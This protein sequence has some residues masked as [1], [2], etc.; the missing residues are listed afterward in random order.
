MNTPIA[1]H[2]RRLPRLARALGGAL[3]LAA[4]LAGTAGTVQLVR[5][6]NTTLIP[7]S[8]YPAP[9]GSLGGKM[10]FG[11]ADATGPALW[12][13]DGTAGGTRVLQRL[14]GLGILPDTPWNDFLVQG[15][16]A[17]V[18][19]ADASGVSSV[20]VTDGTAGGTSR[21][22]TLTGGSTGTPVLEGLLNT[23]VIIS[24]VDTSLVGQL[25]ATDGTP[26]GTHQL[27]TFTAQTGGFLNGFFVA[28]NK[29][30]FVA[31]DPSYNRSIWVSDGTAAGTHQISSTTSSVNSA[32]L[33][34]PQG[35]QLVGN[36]ILYESS[37]LLWSIDTTTDAI[38]NVIAS[39]GIAGFGPPTVQ[40]T[41]LAN[42]GG[43]VLFLGSS[44]IG[45]QNN[46]ELWRSDG[47]TAGTTLV[48]TVTAN[49]TQIEL[50]YPLFEKVGNKVVYIG[51]DGVNGPQ[52]WSSDGTLA[53]TIRLTSATAPASIIFQ[54]AS[55]LS[56]IGGTAY[57]LISDGASTTTYSLWRTDGSAAG[58]QRL[59]G[60][61]TID[62]GEIGAT[63]IAG[64]ATTVYFGVYPTLGAPGS[65]YKY[66]PASNTGTLAKAG[67][68]LFATDEFAFNGG[69]LFFSV[70]DPVVG[71]EPWVSDGTTAGTRLIE[72][73]NPQLA[74]NGSSPDGFV[75]FGGRLAFAADDGIAGRELW[76]SDG[77]AGGTTL[78]ADIN[79]GIA[80][81]N[82]NH[83]FVANDALYFFATDASGSSKFMRLA[84]VGATAQVLATLSPQAINVG[85]SCGADGAVAMGTQI[86]FAANDGQT[87][88]ELWTS[89]GTAEGTHRVA[90]IA[91]GAADA[92]PCYLTALNGRVYFS[93]N[94]P[95]GNELWSS[96]GTAAGT[97]QVADIAPGTASSNPYDLMAFNGTLYF[98]ADDMLHGIELW[99][100]DGTAGGTMLVADIVP[101]ADGSIP[102]LQGILNGRLLLQIFL[103]STPPGTYVSQLW[104]SD[105]TSGGTQAISSQLFTASPSAFVNGTHVFLGAQ[106]TAGVTPWVS[107]GTSGGT[108]A[109]IPPGN[110][111][112]FFFDDFSGITLFEVPDPTKGAQLWRT[113][114]T[115]AGTKLVSVEPSVTN[116]PYS[117]S[118]R[119]HLTV[120]Q[121]FF[122]SATDPI[123]GAELYALTNDPPVAV[124][125]SATSKEDAAVTIDVLAN[126][127]DSDGSLDPTT[128]AI[129]TNP[130]HGS[131]VVSAG[132]VIYTPSTGFAGTDSF[133]Y[134]VK[135]N[136]GATSAPAVITVTVT[137]AVA[138]PPTHGGGGGGAI[139]ALQLL[140][141]MLL[142]AAQFLRANRELLGNC[143]S[144]RWRGRT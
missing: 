101:G 115:T 22:M 97:F 14:T 4:P 42:M 104:S 135:D 88:L 28:A 81:S 99:K 114:G 45:I 85:A 109:L 70:N 29:F 10:L 65:I 6:I 73:L 79:P 21:V 38:S 98:S 128:I 87:G 82:P 143:E 108:H 89:D 59:G 96:D 123:L 93:A 129:T 121:Q 133:A 46:L 61:P 1:V 120:G 40:G 141:A 32:A 48:T 23:T 51:D 62:V 126:D 106:D 92:A 69:L 86:Y 34:N 83:L 124:A 103:G 39:S 100:S 15:S 19:S 60:L 16:R 50:S 122:F 119:Q 138:P 67:L 24:N 36:L 77:T 142:W 71:D 72:D 41:V 31:S 55:P 74:G 105:G 134:T 3:L 68:P 117:A 47:T 78:L 91:A 54:V 27:T 144:W 37:G 118:A 127:S 95:Q 130:A 5:N 76:I 116:T 84:K 44:G 17:F 140:G 26:A 90:D 132:K 125:D 75:N 111:V 56:V 9:L 8:S 107:D 63:R 25:F 80:S 57:V 49:A 136:Q 102:Y 94:G 131:A 7:Q 113:D 64:D 12:S 139:T 43:F 112:L 58:T 33:Y 53:N 11:A 13:T 30:Y 110:S 66:L 52:L 137:A 35:F 20:W 2:L 18:V